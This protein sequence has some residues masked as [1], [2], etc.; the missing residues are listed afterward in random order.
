ML[1]KY[2]CYIAPLNVVIEEGL[3]FRHDD[4]LVKSLVISPGSTGLEEDIKVWFAPSKKIKNQEGLP[5]DKSP[6]LHVGNGLNYSIMI[7]LMI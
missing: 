5:I 1:L 4:E 3:I 2:L 6:E 7:P